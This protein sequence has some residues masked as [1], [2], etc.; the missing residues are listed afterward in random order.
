MN[1]ISDVNKVDVGI[2]PAALNG[3]N[4]GLYFPM[5]HHRKSLFAQNIGVMAAAATSVMQVLQASDSAGTGSKVVTG[6]TTT[7]TANTLASQILLAIVTA[8]GGVHVAGD[9]VT[10]NGLVYEAAAADVPTSRVY[11]VGASGAASAAALLA[12]INSTDVNIGLP[13]FT[14]VSGIVAANTIL[15]LTA[16]EPGD[17]LVTAVASAATTVVSTGEAVAFI[18][19]D[20]AELDVNNGFNHVAIRV[21]NSAAMGTGIALIRDNSRYSPD[22]K[23]ADSVN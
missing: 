5:T 15:T 23:V 19:V 1:K 8:A 12:K 3:A 21:T 17:N 20:A 10:I 11:A 9:T 6:K 14:A 16:D 4:T 18:E 13:D 2:A 22:Q 7:I